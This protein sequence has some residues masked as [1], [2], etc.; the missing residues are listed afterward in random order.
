M[1]LLCMHVLLVTKHNTQHNY[2]QINVAAVAHTSCNK[3][4]HVGATTNAANRKAEFRIGIP[5]PYWRQKERM[6]PRSG[7]LCL[8]RGGGRHIAAK[9]G[10]ERCGSYIR[11]CTYSPPTS[12]RERVRAHM[13]VRQ[14]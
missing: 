13:H 9:G 8:D 3:C 10:G 11:I 2:M 4:K 6:D 14:G 1:S 7:T 12:A 5:H